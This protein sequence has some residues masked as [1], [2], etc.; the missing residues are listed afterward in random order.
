MLQKVPLPKANGPSDAGSAHHT[1]RSVQHV[2][3]GRWSQAEHELDQ[4]SDANRRDHTIL[5][6]LTDSLTCA[7][8]R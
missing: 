1:R 2:D 6:Q 5:N 7:R 4:Q 3:R 8:A